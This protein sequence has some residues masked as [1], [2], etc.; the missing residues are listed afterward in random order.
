MAR[1]DPLG[2]FWQ[3]TVVITRYLGQGSAG[4]L[5]DV[6]ET[7][8]GFM[9]AAPGLIPGGQGEPGDAK[10]T[11]ALPASVGYVELRSRVSCPEFLGNRVARVIECTVSNLGSVA[12]MPAHVDV[13][14]Q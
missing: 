14:L 5:F 3:H 13:V 7:V 9:S 11:L 6:P 1:K 8:Q 10:A 4:E 2:V 12:A